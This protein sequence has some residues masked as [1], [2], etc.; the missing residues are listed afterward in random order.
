MLGIIHKYYIII[1]NIIKSLFW[2]KVNVDWK[3]EN[4]KGAK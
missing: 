1:I 3:K 2:S 4:G